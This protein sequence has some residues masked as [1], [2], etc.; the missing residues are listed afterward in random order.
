VSIIT[1]EFSLGLGLSIPEIAIRGG[2]P[3]WLPVS[4]G[5]IP[6]LFADFTTEGAGNHYWYNG[7]QYT[8]FA[9]WNTAIGGVFTRTGGATYL[10]G[11]NIVAAGTGAA[12]FPTDVNNVPQGLRLTG[13]VTN[14]VL[15]SAGIT[16]WNNGGSSSVTL[17]DTGIASPSGENWIRS[18]E[19][20]ANNF[21]A[22]WCSS[23]F[24][25]VSGNYYTRS[26]LVRSN[27]TRRY[28]F[29]SNGTTG[30]NERSSVFDTQ[31]GTWGQSNGSGNVQF[32]PIPV[33]GGW[34]IAFAAKA[35]STAEFLQL[36]MSNVAT[37]T[38]DP[39]YQGDGVSFV[40]V[41]SPQVTA[42]AFLQDY[43]STT[44]ATATQNADSYIVGPNS[45]LPFTGFNASAG[46]IIAK[47]SIDGVNTNGVE[48]NIFSVDGAN[49]QNVIGLGLPEHLTGV[50]ADPDFYIRTGNALQFDDQPS[51]G[52]AISSFPRNFGLAWQNNDARGVYSG[53]L[54][55][56]HNSVSVPTVDR[57]YIGNEVTRNNQLFGNLSS[58][59]YYPSRLPDAN[60]QALAP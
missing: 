49:T 41:A 40:D 57:L 14:I 10:Q 2:L 27:A 58:I 46:T 39:T 50:T 45:G 12:R 25:T 8:S 23:T 1:D 19:K 30:A 26:L 35:A 42:S 17:S 7:R 56:S 20:N 13:A 36:D 48:Q 53:T 44:S 38:L 47:T 3:S 15:Q 31:T 60:L 34:L 24:T 54:G 9:A 59:A 22:F 28:L 6:T 52:M 18:T 29:V 32:P 37:G 55:S 51:V 4:G 11:G 21:H 5:V 33:N 43:V 16:T